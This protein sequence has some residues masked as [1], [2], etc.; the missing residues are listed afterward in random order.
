MSQQQSRGP[1]NYTS[2]HARQTNNNATGPGVGLSGSRQM[3]DRTI[4]HPPIA[5]YF[6]GGG[7]VLLG[8]ATNGWQMFTTFVAFWSLLNPNGTPVDVGK[9]PMDFMIC[10]LIAVSFQFSLIM[11]VFRI[12]TTWKRKT[13]VNVKGSK[14]AAFRSTAIEIVQHVNLVMVW[15]TIGFVVDTVGDYTFVSF[16]TA[17]LD[18]ATAIFVVFLY[19]IGLYALSTIAFVRSIEFLWAGFRA[20]DTI[21]AQ[22][23]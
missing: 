12:D 8:L 2:K 16:Y 14:G 11:L 17:R 6:I 23:S 1:F 3:P 15:G 9:Q 13:A 4:H 10:A 19:A 18:P 20:A 21:K 5:M 22:R 7:G